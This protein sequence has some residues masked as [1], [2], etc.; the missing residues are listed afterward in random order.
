VPPAVA[1][2]ETVTQSTI[3]RSRLSSGS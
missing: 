1:S 3:M 2:D